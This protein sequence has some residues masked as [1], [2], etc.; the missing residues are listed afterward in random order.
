[1]QILSDDQNFTILQNWVP[2]YTNLYT[3]KKNQKFHYYIGSEEIKGTDVLKTFK[4]LNLL[5]NDNT[6]FKGIEGNRIMN[7]ETNVMLQMIYW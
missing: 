4:R 2:H 5:S 6:L 1:M 7:G 3:Q